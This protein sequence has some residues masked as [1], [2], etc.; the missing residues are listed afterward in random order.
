MQPLVERSVRPRGHFAAGPE[1]LGD[2][3]HLDLEF[4]VQ[5]EVVWRDLAVTEPTEG[6]HHAVLGNDA[7]VDVEVGDQIWIH[8]RP[9]VR[10]EAGDE[11]Q[12]AV[13]IDAREVVQD[14]Q[15]VPVRNLAR[16]GW[17]ASSASRISGERAAGGRGC[18]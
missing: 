5:V 3:G 15:G 17:I 8:L 10:A 9:G 7:E 2:A 11:V 16:Y 14:A 18:R 13:A 4:E 6:R 1:T 12:R